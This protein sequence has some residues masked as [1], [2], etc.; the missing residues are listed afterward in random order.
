MKINVEKNEMRRS[1]DV[2][3]IRHR[4]AS[5]GGLAMMMMT[6]RLFYLVQVKGFFWTHSMQKRKQSEE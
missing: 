5:C 1:E 4:Q 2:T 3:K 6:M